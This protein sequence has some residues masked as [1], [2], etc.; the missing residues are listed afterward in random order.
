MLEADHLLDPS[1]LRC[2][3]PWVLRLIIDRARL[4]DKGLELNE[5]TFAIS[6]EFG[7]DLYVINSDEFAE[8]LVVRCR[9][10]NNYDHRDSVDEGIILEKNIDQNLTN[11]GT[12]FQDCQPLCILTTKELLN[13]QIPCSHS[14]RC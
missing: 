7:E 3:S 12:K 2:D 11:I 8:K 1:Q 9:I 5:I 13:I 10:V 14:W 6:Q 4:I